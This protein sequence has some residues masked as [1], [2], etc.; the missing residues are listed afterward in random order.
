MF[1]FIFL[2]QN[3][4]LFEW[5]KKKISYLK[6]P[7]D[8]SFFMKIANSIG[9]A[10]KHWPGYENIAQKLLSIPQHAH[11]KVHKLF[12]PNETN[13]NVINH[14]DMFI[15]NI[16]FRYDANNCP[17][18]IRFVSVIFLLFHKNWFSYVT[19]RLF[20]YLKHFFS[21]VFKTG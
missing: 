7:I 4:E 11:E 5:H 9:N 18:D 20:I 16:L 13:F 19:F 14:G 3:V 8:R 2:V 6:M 10:A 21:Y 15:N 1:F 12:I 17:V